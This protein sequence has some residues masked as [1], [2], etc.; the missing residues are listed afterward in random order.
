MCILYILYQDMPIMVQEMAVFVSLLEICPNSNFNIFEMRLPKVA[1]P[2]CMD[3][4]CTMS[5]L[6][7]TNIEI[8]PLKQTSAVP[9]EG[10]IS[11]Q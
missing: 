8:S 10:A 9:T 5:K 11:C 7:R 1:S 2:S 3:L 6:K 4:S